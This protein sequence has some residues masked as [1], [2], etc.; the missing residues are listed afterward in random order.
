MLDE[1]CNLFKH[2]TAS[3]YIHYIV[4]TSMALR[5]DI[6]KA[7][8]ARMLVSCIPKAVVPKCHAIRDTDH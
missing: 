4:Q 6:D 7:R 2:A 5:S 3:H 1:L 8:I